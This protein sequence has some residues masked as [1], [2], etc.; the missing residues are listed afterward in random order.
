M[1]TTGINTADYKLALRQQE[2][3]A[4]L[5]TKNLKQWSALA[6]MLGQADLGERIAE[7]SAKAKEAADAIHR[8]EHAVDHLHDD[9]DHGVT[10]TK[11]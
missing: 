3:L 5:L 1:C 7:A 10:I 4:E 6:S 9:H 8:A 11:V 2:D